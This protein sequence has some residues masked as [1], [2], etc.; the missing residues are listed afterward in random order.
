[1][2]GESAHQICRRLFQLNLFG[3][4]EQENGFS[5]ECA[6]LVGSTEG[7]EAV[8]ANKKGRAASVIGSAAS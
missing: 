7:G 8:K 3:F 4:Y 2:A 5:T 1:M 6:R